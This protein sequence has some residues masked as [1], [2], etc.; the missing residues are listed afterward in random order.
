MLLETRNDL[1]VQLREKS[2]RILNE[3]LSDTI[4]LYLQI[5]SAHWNIKGPRFLMLHEF[6]DKLYGIFIE[7]ADDI[8]ERATAL[9]GVAY[10]SADAVSKSSNFGAYIDE[11]SDEMSHIK[12]ITDSVAAYGKSIREAIDQTEGL[13]D[14]GTADLFTGISREVDKQLW[15][16]ESHLS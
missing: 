8:A 1:P 11:T 13:G 10:G 2:V 16:L 4:G 14:K 15:F 7:T 9:G 5:K 3:R 12:A 6:F